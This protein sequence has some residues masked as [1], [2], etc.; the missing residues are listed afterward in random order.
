MERGINP[1]AFDNDAFQL[2][3][4]NG[5]TEI[6]RLLVN[7][8]LEIDVAA[9][10]NIALRAA[11]ANCHTEIVRLLLDLPLERGVDLAANKNEALRNAC[12]LNEEL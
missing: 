3:C 4:E 7:L 11:C 10:N 1:L 12:F 5:H 9:D 6:V 2:A 8:P